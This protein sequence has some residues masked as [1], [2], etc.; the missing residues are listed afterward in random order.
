MAYQFAS[1]DTS[2]GPHNRHNPEDDINGPYLDGV[3]VTHGNPRQHVWSLFAGLDTSRCCGLGHTNTREARFFIGN[4]SFCDSGNP[5]HENWAD[6]L[7]TD[8]PLWDGIANCAG[9][10]SCCT[11]HPG[12]WF[13]TILPLISMDDIE[14]RVCGDQDTDDE[15][16]PVVLLEIYVK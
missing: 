13:H 15:D 9:S 12:P 3:S 10:T 7:F 11:L 8:H 16:T 5:T 14:V 6:A 1:P 2:G 4:N